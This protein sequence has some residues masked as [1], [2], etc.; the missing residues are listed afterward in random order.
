MDFV[1]K[2]ICMYSY[3]QFE[4]LGETSHKLQEGTE[5]WVEREQADMK[6]IGSDHV[7]DSS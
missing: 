7:L 1:I 2:Q 4:Y 3:T 6:G 5:T